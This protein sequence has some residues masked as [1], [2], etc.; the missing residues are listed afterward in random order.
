MN[1]LLNPENKRIWFFYLTLVNLFWVGMNCPDL[2]QGFFFLCTLILLLLFTQTREDKIPTTTLV[3]F[4]AYLFFHYTALFYYGFINTF[5]FIKEPLFLLA[6]YK[7]GHFLGR[8]RLPDWQGNIILILLAMVSGFV[9]FAFLSIYLAPNVS[10]YAATKVGEAKAGRTGTMIWTGGSGGF[11]PI[12]GIQGN[13]GSAFLPVFL[14]G[15]IQELVKSKKEYIMIL[16]V[17]GFFIACGFYTN[18]LLKNRGPFAIIAGIMAVIGLYNIF[19]GPNRLTPANLT[20]K[21]SLLLCSILIAGSLFSVMPKAED[22]SHLGVIARFTEEGYDSPRNMIWKNCIKVIAEHP[23]GG[24]MDFFGHQYAH[25]IWLDVGY[26]SGIVAMFFLIIFHI[27]HFKDMFT[28]ALG[29]L[30]IHQGV[31]SG[32]IA[33]FF[34]IFISLFTEPVGKGYTIYYAMTFFYC[35]LLKRLAADGRNLKK[36]LILNDITYRL[37]Y[38]GRVPSGLYKQE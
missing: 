24:R 30:P 28:L 11:G 36:E 16:G 35:G 20:R 37:R 5:T 3:I 14:F 32:M 13:L 25:N 19:F 17:T 10:M 9:I 27:I 18:I 2:S 15:A 12:L 7:F 6:S 21:I 29:R 26:D 23:L 38:A 8:T 4:L 31:I 34:I 1:Y 33:M 22:V